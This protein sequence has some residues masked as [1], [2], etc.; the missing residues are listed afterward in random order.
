[1]FKNRKFGFYAVTLCL[2]GL[3]YTAL[4]AAL[5]S[6][7]TDI[8]RHF[9]T[10]GGGGWSGRAIELPA[11]VGSFLAVPAAFVCGRLTVKNGPRQTLIVSAALAALGSV[12]LAAANG[13]DVYGGAA[14]GSYPLFFLSS[15]LVRCACAL[16]DIGVFTLCAGWFIRCRGRVMGIVTL[17]APLLGAVGVGALVALISGRLDGDCRPFFLALAGALA[18]LALVTRFLLRDVPEEAGLYP[19]GAGR[20]PLS[21]PDDDTPPGGKQ[22]LKDRRTWLLLASY[23]PLVAVAS[24]CM[25]AVAARFL[26]LGGE[27]LWLS[28][29]KWL[30][31]GAILSIPA[32]YLFG[33]LDDYAGSAAASVA[34]AVTELL[35]AAALLV[36]PAEGSL[37]W[38]ILLSVGVAC[39]MGGVST[40]VPCALAR[41]YGRR[42]FAAAG[43]I[44][45]PALL[46]PAAAAPVAA[47][48]LIGMG[49]GR[50]AC[51]ALIALAAVGLAASALLFSVR[52]ANA[53]D[54]GRA[55]LDD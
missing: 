43:Q 27:G 1:M 36:M 39:L 53:S 11:M 25:G 12:G 42:G 38:E 40:M 37:L 19:D 46:L 24:G 34:L 17:G 45:L 49:M 13:L 7:Q 23:G 15:A 4:C 16:I 18:V 35:P 28:A 54:R 52:D 10:A 20:A 6:G 33:L 8:L 14:A 47:V 5:Q 29:G 31:L 50:T 9:V 3:A 55:P 51:V 22:V 26:S 21:E 44:V 48:W 41:V 2:T 30:A 32:S